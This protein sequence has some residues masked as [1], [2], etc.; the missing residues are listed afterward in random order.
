VSSRKTAAS[1]KKPMKKASA[2]GKPAKGKGV[3]ARAKAAPKKPT[4]AKKAPAAK[5]AVKKAAPKAAAKVAKPAPSKAAAK[6][7]TNGAAKKP[8]APLP[9]AKSAKAS[10]RGAA[11]PAA[12]S[13]RGSAGGRGNGAP[14]LAP[15]RKKGA[16]PPSEAPAS[17]K[18][19]VSKV[20]GSKA[21]GSK[22]PASRGPAS[23]GPG[24]KGAPGSVRPPGSVRA[25]GSSRMPRVELAPRSPAS[26]APSIPIP[27]KEVAEAPSLEQRAH[28]LEQRIGR[29]SSDFR[30]QYRES[31]EMSWIY[32]DTA[33][34]GIVYTIE[35]LSSALRGNNDAAVVDSSV[36]PIF[37][38]I[39]RHKQAIDYL[40]EM[41]E[42]KRSTISI[43]L[44]KKIY[45]IL[46][47]EEGDVKTVKYRRDV[48]QHRLYFHEYAPPDRI[49]YKVR[50][51]VDWVNDR[52]KKNMDT[53]RIAAK[54]H[55]DLARAYPFTHASGKVA[56][57]FMNFLLLRAGFP[58][59]IIH[60]KERQRYYEALKAPSPS[61]LVQMMRDS[62]DDAVSSVEK[63]LDEHETNVRAFVT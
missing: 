54:A 14:A 44:L 32:H 53:L 48:P 34:E 57:L 52:E 28:W 58:P 13:A 6:A 24:S 45:V 37:D 41:A 30:D 46:H 16:P 19:P 38:A 9:S 50:Q 12:A 27:V 62:V 5:V 15:A 1:K 8:P 21:P 2:K 61:T 47:P 22:G 51:T 7:G 42:K 35:E 39:R 59:A 3:S 31:F 33:L 10:A 56:R 60:A 23:R 49:A 4:P 55:Y 20:P 40:R 17:A 29:Q 36:M 11:P 18:A 63:L 43:D 26:I 25:P